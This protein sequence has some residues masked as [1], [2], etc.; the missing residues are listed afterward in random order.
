M[1]PIVKKIIKRTLITLLVIIL[2]LAGAIGIALNFVFT[3]EKLTPKVEEIAKEYVKGDLNIGAVDLTF[4]SSFPR[5]GIRIKDLRIVSDAL[6]DGIDSL[7]SRRDTLVRL[8]ELRLGINV[9]E[10]LK[11]KQVKVDRIR[12]KHPQITLYNDSLGRYNWDIVKEQVDT[13]PTDTIADTTIVFTGVDLKYLQIQNARIRYADRVSK[14]FVNVDSLDFLLKGDINPKKFEITVDVSDKS[15]SLALDRTRYFR[16]LPLGLKAKVHFDGPNKR[17]VFDDTH[18]E[19]NGVQLDI[20]GWFKKDSTSVDMDINYAVASPSVEAIFG[21]IPK[22]FIKEELNVS[23]GDI[24]L[25]GSAVGTYAEKQ[26]PVIKLDASIGKVKAKYEGMPYGI[27]DLEAK[28]NTL[29]DIK[30]PK[31]SYANLNIFHFKGA[32]SEVAAV[33][34]AKELLG[35]PLI[36]CDINTH[37]NLNTMLKLFPIQNILLSGTTDADIK[38]TFRL[39]D[40]KRQDIGKLKINGK[41]DADS[42]R[43]ESDSMGINLNSDMHLKFASTD[44][45]SIRGRLNKMNFAMGDMKVRATQLSISTKALSQ[46]D[47]SGVSPLRVNI[48]AS[49]LFFKQDSITIFTKNLRSRNQIKS[50]AVNK[51]LPKIDVSLNVDTI[52]SN[53][54]GTRGLTKK[55]VTSVNLEKI[56]TTW[57]SNAMAKFEE[58]RASTPAYA[59]P[60]K[61][62]KGSIVKEGNDIKLDNIELEVGQSNITLSGQVE[63]LIKSLRQRALIT[64]TLNVKADTLNFNQLLS[65]VVEDA[66]INSNTTEL[67]DTTIT[68][69]VGQT[70]VV[71]DSMSVQLVKIPRQ[72]RFTLSTDVKTVFWDKIEVNN[73]KGKVEINRGAIH[74]NALKLRQHGSDIIATLAYKANSRKKSAEA[75]FCIS[76]ENADIAYVVNAIGLDTVMPMLSPL[77]GKVSCALATNIQLDSMMNYDLHKIKAGIHINASKLTLMDSETFAKISKV[78]MFKNKKENIIDT[79]AL[80]IMVDSGRIEILPFVA[81]VDRYRAIVG[82]DQDVDM[83]DI[84]YHVSIVKSPLPFKAGVNITGNPDDFD[85]DITKAKLKN[86][87][88]PEIQ[89]AYDQQTYNQRLHI[90]TD[91]Y[92]ISGIEMPAALKKVV[93]DDTADK[94]IAQARAES[95]RIERDTTEIVISADTTI[96]DTAEP[97][98]TPDTLQSSINE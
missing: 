55:L 53:F 7:R 60:L 63:N 24:S 20:N 5:L 98:A 93:G 67:S 28:F 15:T 85:I 80:N 39:S 73:I 21:L 3:P 18:F 2:L 76:W 29:I 81:N 94:I 45:L 19:I 38:A 71:T 82:G 68:N 6:N 41:I 48:R 12:L 77:K 10:Y 36:D 14:T 42:L 83:T 87:A 49:R 97:I 33:A 17:F 62:T 51:K 74:M 47:T 52:I 89:A 35:D 40:L 31:S 91:C 66:E 37:I 75:N 54:Y 50:S 79:L 78:L 56:D 9:E 1:K 64:A 70:D 90:V 44:T 26:M 11:T 46:R 69:V 23:S 4:F 16:R 88:T 8:D 13:I 72:I 57:T 65:A 32:D 34:S 30:K 96:V 95:R 25:S 84:N 27:E 86:H 92:R 59:L 61:A 58:V 22:S 43:V